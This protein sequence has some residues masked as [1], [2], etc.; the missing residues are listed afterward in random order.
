MIE[1]VEV[2]GVEP[3]TLNFYAQPS[4]S[5]DVG[6]YRSQV[7]ALPHD[8]ATLTAIN[9]ALVVHEHIAPAYGVVLS[10]EDRS[11]A[12]H[13]SIERLLEHITARDERPLHEARP[14]PSRVAG[15]CWHFV[16]LLVAIL[17]V[18]GTPARARCG[19]ADYFNEGRFEDHW[20]CEYW[21]AADRR[22]VLVDA[23]LDAMQRS[24]FE[25]DFDHLDVPRDRFIVA[26]EAWGRCR[27]GTAD[28]GAFGLS[29][30]GLFGP[31]Y[32]AANL[33]RDAA[34]LQRLE[35]LPD[36]TWAAMPG[37]RDTVDDQLSSL[38]DDLGTLT[39]S[40]DTALAEL[41]R[42]CTDNRLRVP[43]AR[44]GES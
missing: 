35:M 11:T 31:W 13:R 33:M 42:L 14:A 30:T 12:H 40:P 32:V 39:R 15:N 36:E 19:F 37:P 27:A 4:G 20:V 9:H 29:I 1:R 26:G 2:A 43:E 18:H 16:V 38:L 6:R 3:P 24:M 44:T 10:D 17:R 23:Q 7:E 25:I 8:I 34:A 21:H 41:Q 28:P 5:T 22:W